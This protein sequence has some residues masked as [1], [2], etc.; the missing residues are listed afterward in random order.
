MRRA[1]LEEYIGEL[2]NEIL[3]GKTGKKIQAPYAYEFD[4]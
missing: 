4:Q 1:D 3:K 2:R